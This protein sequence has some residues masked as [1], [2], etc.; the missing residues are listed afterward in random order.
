MS[1]FV[2][3]KELGVPFFM[4]FHRPNLDLR[5]VVTV[6]IHDRRQLVT[7]SLVKRDVEISLHLSG[8][9][10]MGVGEYVDV[11]VQLQETIEGITATDDSA[12]DTN[13]GFIVSLDSDGVL[14]SVECSKAGS[15][16]SMLKD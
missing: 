14:S 7:E 9:V 13:I 12:I 10:R 5:L 6:R 8:E 1:T 2:E 3:S 16:P 11:Q 15:F 4:S